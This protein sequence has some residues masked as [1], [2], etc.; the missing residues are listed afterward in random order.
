MGF[1]D[2]QGNYYEGDRQGDDMEVP[3]RPSPLHRWVANGWLFDIDT[4]RKA[5]IAELNI[6]S[7]K[8]A[9]QLTA[10]YPEFDKQTW[11]DQQR[12]ALAWSADNAAQTP[13]LDAIAAYREID[14]LVLLQKTLAK[15]LSF[16]SASDYLVG[17][18]Q[19]YEDQ[20]KAAGN[21]AELDAIQ[22]V[23]TLPS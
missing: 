9:D 6:E 4:A 20:I 14:R 19:K 1:I 16:Q 7:Q 10:E 8:T 23:F 2:R 21:Q 18:R 15:V 13:R 22:P 12:E 3:Q 17:V 5:E 11:P